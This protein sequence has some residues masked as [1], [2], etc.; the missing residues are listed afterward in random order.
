MAKST[1]SLASVLSARFGVEA[2][3]ASPMTVEWAAAH[4]AEAVPVAT[5][6]A[7]WKRLN[8]QRRKLGRVTGIPQYGTPFFAAW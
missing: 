1:V 8:G 4:A 3:D 5:V 6:V 7:Q 2:I